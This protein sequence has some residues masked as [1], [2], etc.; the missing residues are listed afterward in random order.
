M[1]V[2]LEHDALAEGGGA[3]WL[4]DRHHPLRHNLSLG[5][6]SADESKRRSVGQAGSGS[7]VEMMAR[8]EIVSVSVCQRL[9]C[10]FAAMADVACWIMDLPVFAQVRSA[11]RGCCCGTWLKTLFG[12]TCGSRW[13]VASSPLLAGPVDVEVAVELGLIQGCKV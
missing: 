3:V 1:V 10:W 8:S 4:S 5:M 7:S 6:V 11:C 2:D 13:R 12:S 9:F